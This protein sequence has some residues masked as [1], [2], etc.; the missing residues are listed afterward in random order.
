LANVGEQMQAT[1]ERTLAEPSAASASLVELSHP[2]NSYFVM[3]RGDA[4]AAIRAAQEKLNCELGVQGSRRR[5]TT[6]E[7]VEGGCTVLTDRFAELCGYLL[8]QARTSTGVSAMYVSHQSIYTNTSQARVA[9]ARLVAASHAY[10]ACVRPPA[11]DADDPMKARFTA[12]TQGEQVR[13][14]DVTSRVMAHSRMP[15]YAPIS[16]SGWS[17][18]GGRHR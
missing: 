15:L 14:I 13:D 3:M 7:L 2:A 12:L 10:L 8:V 18:Q 1:L 4:L 9:L 16:Q 5:L 6:W 11:F 17:V